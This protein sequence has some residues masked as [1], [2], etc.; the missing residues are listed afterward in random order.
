MYY[1]ILKI[2]KDLGC[3]PIIDMKNFPTKYNVKNKIDKTYNAWEYYFEPL[4][5]YKLKDIYKSKF[6]IV[7]QIQRK[8]K[9]FDSFENLTLNIQ[10]L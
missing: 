1:T 3:I 4:N 7:C 10:N 9:E 8:L 2:A 5:N 6:V